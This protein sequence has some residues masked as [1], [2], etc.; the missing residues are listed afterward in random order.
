MDSAW[1]VNI[2]QHS[3]LYGFAIMLVKL[4]ANHWVS[5][6]GPRSMVAKVNSAN[7]Y[8]KLQFRYQVSNEVTLF[9]VIWRWDVPTLNL[10]SDTT[11][12]LSSMKGSWRERLQRLKPDGWFLFFVNYL[13]FICSSIN[14]NVQFSYKNIIKVKTLWKDNKNVANW[15]EILKIN[16][17]EY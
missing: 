13:F 7:K 5:Q 12:R 17:L 3:P 8:V 16:I 1:E 9:M 2:L 10:V 15:M 11:D 6:S 4:A 14:C